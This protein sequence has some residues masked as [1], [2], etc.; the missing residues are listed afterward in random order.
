M[1]KKVSYFITFFICC[2]LLTIVFTSFFNEKQKPAVSTETVLPEVKMDH[3]SILPNWTD[4]EYHDYYG[5]IE[6]YGLRPDP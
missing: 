2:I 3:R 6:R 5:T 1:D 4:G